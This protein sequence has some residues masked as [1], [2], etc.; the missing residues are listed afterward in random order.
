MYIPL[1]LVPVLGLLFQGDG[2]EGDKLPE[3]TG[4]SFMDQLKEDP[5]GTLWPYLEGLVWAIAIFVIGRIVV[6]MV[7]GVLRKVMAKANVDEILINFLASIASGVMMLFVIIGALDKLGVPTGSMVA[8]VGAAGLAVGFAMQDSLSNFASGVMLI[9]FRP[10]KNGDFVEAGGCTGV[11]EKIQIFTTIMKT[12]DNREIIVPNGAIF[13][14]VITNYSARDTRRVDMIFGIG[15]DD[16]LLKAKQILKDIIA[17]DERI[18]QDPAPAI[19]I[20]DL[21]DSCVNFKVR[22]WVKSG[23]YWDV[24]SDITETVKLTFDKEGISIP[25]PQT[26]VHL[27]KVDAAG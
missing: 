12:G 23:D 21:G 27:Y 20:N 18:L 2:A 11:V 10:F 5:V 24:L 1:P 13:G 7:T 6:K 16:D 15:Y 26:D 17:A 19:A 4:P 9:I 8:L 25:Y 14:G 22:P 3:D